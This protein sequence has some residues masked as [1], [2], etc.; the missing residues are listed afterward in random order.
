MSVAG[1][2]RYCALLDRMQ[3]SLATGT[4]DSAKANDRCGK[5]AGEEQAFRHQH[6]VAA[7]AARPRMRSFIDPFA[8]PLVVNR[9]A[10]GKEDTP[11]AFAEF[12]ERGQQA[13]Y[14]VEVRASIGFFVAA[15]S[16]RRIEDGVDAAG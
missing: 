8:T 11:R 10:R 7:K 5:R 4:V 6:D 14:P 13:P 3:Q 9:S 15:R 12:R 1:T 16:T 2:H